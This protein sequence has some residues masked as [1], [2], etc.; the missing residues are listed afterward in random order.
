MT[1]YEYLQ[2]SSVQQITSSKLDNTIF[3]YYIYID[4][5]HND[6]M[7]TK[8]IVNLLM[9]LMLEVTLGDIFS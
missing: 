3:S 1:I 5:L 4:C 6:S 7:I 8:E 2:E 9:S